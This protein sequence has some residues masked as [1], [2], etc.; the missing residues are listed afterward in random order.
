LPRILRL[1]RT[2]SL[3]VRESKSLFLLVVAE[4]LEPWRGR[5]SELVLPVA[6]DTAVLGIGFAMAS[7]ARGPWPVLVKVNVKRSVNSGLQGS[8]QGVPVV[9]KAVPV[10]VVAELVLVAQWQHGLRLRRQ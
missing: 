5:D 6:W 9:A 10:P 7:R 4:E 3:R 8:A 2:G 1:S